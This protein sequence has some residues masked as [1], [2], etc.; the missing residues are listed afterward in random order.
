MAAEIVLLW[1]NMDK[2]DKIAL[3]KLVQYPPR[4]SA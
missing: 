4:E 3:P 2:L 1:I